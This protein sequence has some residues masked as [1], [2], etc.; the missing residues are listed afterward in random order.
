[1]EQLSEMSIGQ[2]DMN[3]YHRY[4]SDQAR[5]ELM[6]RRALKIDKFLDTSYGHDLKRDFISSNRYGRE[7]NRRRSDCLPT[8]GVAALR[9]DLMGLAATRRHNEVQKVIDHLAYELE[10]IQQDRCDVFKDFTKSSYL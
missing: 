7:I 10:C 2:E 8:I 3:L 6:K 4:L 1:M 9:R 5:L